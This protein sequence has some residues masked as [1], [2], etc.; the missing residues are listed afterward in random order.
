MILRHENVLTLAASLKSN[1]EE[2]KH[3]D[4]SHVHDIGLYMAFTEKQTVLV[5]EASNFM[6]NTNKLAAFPA[7]TNY[8][9][10]KIFLW[11]L[12]AVFVDYRTD[13]GLV[14]DELWN[15]SM[16]HTCT[17]CIARLTVLFTFRKVME[18][19]GYAIELLK[20][21]LEHLWRIHEHT[22]LTCFLCYL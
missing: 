19:P 12:K 18:S 4:T 6:T 14:S 16:I 1:D 15:S 11:K 22:A 9:S 5:R 10:V 2:S 8:P 3:F 17:I 7:P 20:L 21:D 13:S